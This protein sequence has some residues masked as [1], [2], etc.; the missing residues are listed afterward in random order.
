M[1]K[2]VPITR[3]RG[4]Q[5]SSQQHSQPSTRVTKKKKDIH[6]S[7]LVTQLLYLT[8]SFLYSLIDQL[9]CTTYTDYVQLTKMGNK[10]YFCCL[11]DMLK[12]R[13]GVL[14]S[15]LNVLEI[16]S[17]ILAL[18]LQTLFIRV[19]NNMPFCNCYVMIVYQ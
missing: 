12:L 4:I 8:T 5:I 16:Q 1:Q 7:F 11:V 18:L 14:I 19:Y 6:Y 10:P 9:F 15:H 13:I 2:M 17:H 3:P